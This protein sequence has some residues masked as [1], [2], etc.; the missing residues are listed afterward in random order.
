MITT[1]T[2]IIFIVFIVAIF[3]LYKLFR[4]FLKASLVALVAFCFPWIVKYLGLP[5][6]ITADIITGIQFAIC[7]LI[8]FFMYE[9]LHFIIY[10][11]K[12][13]LYPLKSLARRKK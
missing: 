4:L 6:S 11:F 7:G 2:I 12:I 1:E 13:I 9:F 10:L 3:I 5:L 8:L